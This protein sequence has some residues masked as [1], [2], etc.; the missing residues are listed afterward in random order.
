MLGIDAHTRSGPVL[1]GIFILC[2]DIGKAGL[3]RVQFVASDAPVEDLEPACGGVEL[4]TGLGA[5]QRNRER[6]IVVAKYDDGFL[7][8]LSLD[9]MLCIIGCG[10]SLK[11]FGIGNVVA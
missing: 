1:L 9:R 2:V 7:V 4:P 10:E 5:R 11:R 6:K 3:D 8:A